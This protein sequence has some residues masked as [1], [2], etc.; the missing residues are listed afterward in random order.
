MPDRDEIIAAARAV[1]VGQSPLAREDTFPAG[2]RP[3]DAPQRRRHPR[4]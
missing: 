3:A 1:L 4:L 2:S